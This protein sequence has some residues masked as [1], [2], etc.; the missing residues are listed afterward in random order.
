MTTLTNTPQWEDRGYN[1]H[2]LELPLVTVVCNWTPHTG[3][4]VQVV[5]AGGASTAKATPVDLDEAKA[6]GLRLARKK[7]AEALVAVDRMIEPV[8]QEVE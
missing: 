4:T 3:Y 1:V 6:L 2:R 5:G 8:P 7:L